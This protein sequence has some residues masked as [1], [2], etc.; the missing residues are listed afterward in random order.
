MRSKIN[1]LLKPIMAVYIYSYTLLVSEIIY[2]A[3]YQTLPKAHD[4]KHMKSSVS[5]KVTT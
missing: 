2:G 3:I 5:P 1:T 4:Q